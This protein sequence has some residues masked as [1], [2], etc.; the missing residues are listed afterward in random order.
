MTFNVVTGPNK[1]CN[2]AKSLLNLYLDF[3]FPPP[4]DV[5]PDSP[6]F[7]IIRKMKR[8]YMH[9]N[10]TGHTPMIAAISKWLSYHV[11]LL[12]TTHAQL[13]WHGLSFSNIPY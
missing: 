9:F 8:I 12:L 11:T 10:N 7:Q 3:S 6:F 5:M 1:I 4:E 13:V 2:G